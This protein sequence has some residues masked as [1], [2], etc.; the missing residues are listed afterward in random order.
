MK[1]EKA[2]NY[3]K[4]SNGYIKFSFRCIQHSPVIQWREPDLP[5]G[6]ESKGKS[7]G[8]SEVRLFS[9]LM[10][11]LDRNTVQFRFPISDFNGDTKISWNWWSFIISQHM[12]PYSVYLCVFQSRK[13]YIHNNSLGIAWDRAVCHYNWWWR[14]IIIN[15]LSSLLLLVLRLLFRLLIVMVYSDSDSRPSIS[16][17]ISRSSTQK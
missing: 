8:G 7:S 10:W 16:Y 14:L 5:P 12:S 15:S 4:D 2:C 17:L 6:M 3:V 1:K 9:L 13:Y 11:W